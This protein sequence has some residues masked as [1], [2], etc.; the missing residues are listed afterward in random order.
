[1]DWGG[2]RYAAQEVGIY[3][4]TRGMKFLSSFGG[5]VTHGYRDNICY[6]YLDVYG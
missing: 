5:R 3:N 1:L 2:F 4:K 6:I